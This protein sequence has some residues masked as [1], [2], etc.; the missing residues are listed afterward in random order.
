MSQISSGSFGG[1]AF[2]LSNLSQEKQVSF[3]FFPINSG[4]IQSSIDLFL[5]SCSLSSFLP[6]GDKYMLSG[7]VGQIT[8]HLGA[9]IRELLNWRHN[10]NQKRRCSLSCPSQGMQM[11]LSNQ[12][13]VDTRNAQHIQLLR[14]LLGKVVF[15]FMLQT[16]RVYSLLSYLGSLKQCQYYKCKIGNK[17]HDLMKILYGNSAIPA[18]ACFLL[19]S[20]YNLFSSK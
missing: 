2:F 15:R 16:T 11:T 20:G 18:C 1:F 19:L 14:V 12:Q 6:L 4:K 17:W 13:Q 10:I 8:R 3:V 5:Q 9:S 7:C